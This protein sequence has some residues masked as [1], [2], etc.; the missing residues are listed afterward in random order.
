MLS[1][2]NNK[3]SVKDDCNE[4]NHGIVVTYLITC[5]C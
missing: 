1:G 5:V 4:L 2:T 3:T